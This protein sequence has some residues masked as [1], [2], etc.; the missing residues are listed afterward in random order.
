[1]NRHLRKLHSDSFPSSADRRPMCWR[2]VT[3]E[4]D[5]GLRILASE[6]DGQRG[7][8]IDSIGG[9]AEWLR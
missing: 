1:M 2:L 3:T 4:V 5:L 9:G 8:I 6:L 7:A